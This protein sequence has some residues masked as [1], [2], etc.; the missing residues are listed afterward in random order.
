MIITLIINQLSNKVKGDSTEGRGC[1]SNAAKLCSS[2]SLCGDLILFYSRK[3][4]N[5]I[6]LQ[7]NSL[8]NIILHRGIV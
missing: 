1:A 5:P 2:F 3:F 7:F 6:Y 4:L 8:N